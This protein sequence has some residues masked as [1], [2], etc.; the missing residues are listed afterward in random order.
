MT[1]DGTDCLASDIVYTATVDGTDW[2]SASTSTWLTF[3]AATRVVSWNPTSDSDA[4]SYAIVVTGTIT[5]AHA[6]SP[7]TASY[8][9]TLT[10]NAMS[11]ALTPYSITIATGTAATDSTYTVAATGASQTISEMT[12]SGTHC[13]PSDVVYTATVDGTD[14]ASAT[15]SAWLTFDA[16]TRAVSWDTSD[17]ANAA[18][19]SI[20]VTGTV[21][22]THASSPF[23]SSESFT[24]TVTT[25]ACAASTETIVM[26][27]SVIS[28]QI[29]SVGDD[30][31]TLNFDE[32]TEDSTYC[33]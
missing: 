21:T 20:V 1:E 29:Y 26:T 12:P 3:D 28:D 18:V 25:I 22:N 2:A 17:A 7:H 31:F 27:P 32:F 24:L 33:V 14:W 10:V 19:Y 4:G 30:L 11:C 23:T 16:A 9:F 8:S 15:T 6:N 13:L 5:N